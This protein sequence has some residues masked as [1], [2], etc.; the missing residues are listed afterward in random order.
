MIQGASQADVG[1]LVISAVRVNSELA[2]TVVVSREHALLA[3]TLGVSYLVVVVNKMDEA[4]VQWKKER[5]DKLSPSSVP[6]SRAAA[7]S[8]SVKSSSFRL[9]SRRIISG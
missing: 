5:F 3:K 4:T 9:R 2:L 6:S 1:L 7:L 8:L